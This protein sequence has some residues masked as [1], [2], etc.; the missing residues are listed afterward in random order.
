MVPD[1]SLQIASAFFVAL[2]MA[3]ILIATQ[4]LHGHLT[5]DS[6]AKVQKLHGKSVPRIGGLAVFLGLVA[7]GLTLAGEA[8]W[9]WWSICLAALPAFGAGLAEDLTNRVSARMRLVASLLAGLAFCLL[10]GHHV[11]KAG[12]P[13][14][15][16]LL[17][18]PW[19]AI[20]LTA[21]LIAGIANALNIIDGVNGLSSGTAIIVFAGF[22]AV[23]GAH[24]DLMLLSIC[25]VC[26]GA[27]AG[28]FV[29][30][31]PLGCI[32][33]GDGGAYMTGVLLA[34]VALLLPLRHPELTM[35]LGLLA[36]AYPVI[37]M[38]ITIQRRMNRRNA[39]PGKADRLH[40]H[41]LLFRGRARRLAYRPELPTWPNSLTTVLVL[42]LPIASVLLM[43]VF[44]T[45]M[46]GTLLGIFVIIFIYLRV[47]RHV[48]LLGRRGLLSRL[49]GLSP[50][51]PA[52]RTN[53]ED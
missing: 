42:P 5:H 9:L 21:I 53:P 50:L 33:L 29:V 39:H 19:I 45:S 51:R 11:D 4:R 20:P 35:F 12:V 22:A 3:L 10:T 7:G 1:W 34:V 43:L 46:T 36:L 15:D 25:L 27:L 31:F 2:T 14:L 41:S 49:L 30:N 52:G 23:A 26:I 6:Q 32:F 24:G 18:I 28:F 17:S 16:L 44:Q 48:A 8:A 47:Y 40:L 38:L 37:E 13:G